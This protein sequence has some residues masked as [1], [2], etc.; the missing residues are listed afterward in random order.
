MA[1]S[2]KRSPA[3]SAGA[4]EQILSQQ[5]WIFN[6][7]MGVSLL[8][9]IVLVAAAVMWRRSVLD[10]NERLLVFH[11]GQNIPVSGNVDVNLLTDKI[12]GLL[13]TP[14]RGDLL[15]A[16]IIRD[17]GIALLIAV[18]VNFSIE[19]YSSARLRQSITYNV[20]SAAYSKV[21]PEEIYTQ[22]A[23][24]VFKSPVYRRNWEVHIAAQAEQIDQNHPVVITATYSYDLENLHDQ[25]I[26]F[27]IELSV[28][29]YDPP[30]DQD[31]PKF[32]TLAITDEHD[33]PLVTQADVN[34][35]INKPANS[36]TF[37][38]RKGNITLNKDTRELS[39]TAICPIRRRVSVRFEVRRAIRVPGHYV[40][41][42]PVP[43]D[44][45]RIVTNIVGFKLAVLPLHPNHQSLRNPQRDTWEFDAGILPYQGFRLT[46]E[47]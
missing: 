33:R 27:P 39:I 46:A 17:L 38:I 6:L 13:T 10:E 1:S 12:S 40:L 34:E 4:S 5:T 37:P 45:I 41:T 23:S 16:D 11:L 15:L 43:A 2:T 8:I 18:F 32:T 25:V 31:V 42:A 7:T 24:N 9:G 26:T 21:I 28:D 22:V 19:K 44:G 20:L 14:D 3:L 30:P 35:V 47:T 36:I 29:L